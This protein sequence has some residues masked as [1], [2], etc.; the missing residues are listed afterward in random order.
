MTDTLKI[1]LAAGLTF[2]AGLAVGPLVIRAAKKLKAGQVIL[3][4]VE[5]HSYKSGTPT[6]G[7]FIFLLPASAV[8][9]ILGYTK[10]AAVAVALT[11]SYATLG[12]LDDF[13]KIKFKQNLGLRAYQ[14]LIG[15]LG[16]AVI[17]TVFCYKNPL[18]GTVIDIPFAAV[19]LNLK[20]WYLPFTMFAF[21][22]LTNAVNLTDGL[23]GLAGSVGIAYFAFF[24]LIIYLRGEAA[25]YFGETVLSDELNGLAVFSAAMAGGIGAF[26]WFN[27]NPATVMMGD[28]G[29]L[30]MGGA[31]A[32]VAVFSRTPLL[33]LVLGVTYIASCVSVIA[34]VISFKLTGKRVLLMAPLHHHFEKKG[35]P[36]QKIVL[37]YALITVAAGLIALAA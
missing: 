15:Q 3:G 10:L 22:A 16:I 31:A 9:M 12:F 5:Q 37:R 26:L 25:D 21:I 19:T 2:A 32:A 1:L 4:Y 6:M 20:W 23:D 27:G 8:S 18:V 36:E 29:S 28:T 11:L 35:L 24:A 30:A 34:Q 33:I 14:K 7:G 13:I 17:V